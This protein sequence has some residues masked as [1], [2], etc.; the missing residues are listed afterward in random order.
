MGKTPELNA[1]Q[2]SR[3]VKNDENVLR[4]A[5]EVI[6]NRALGEEWGRDEGRERKGDTVSDAGKKI[7]QRPL[8]K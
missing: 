5:L 8:W 3:V 2:T 4:L 7:G 1:A 6:G